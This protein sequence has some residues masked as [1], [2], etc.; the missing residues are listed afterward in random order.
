[1][2]SDSKAG[3]TTLEAIRMVRQELGAN[4]TLGASNISFGLPDR[5]IIN[6]AFFAMVIYTGATCLI[7][8]A[9]HLR[10]TVLAS[11]LA[12]GRDDYAMNYIKDYRKRSR[13]QEA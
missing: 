13:A 10:P 5:K 7:M 8:D 6:S 9:G 2:G 3:W 4:I 1:M 11:D 12:L